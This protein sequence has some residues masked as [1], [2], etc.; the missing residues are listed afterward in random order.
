MSS[1][2]GGT[3]LAI[4]GSAAI[5][6]V[7]SYESGKRVS[8]A[9]DKAS[10]RTAQTTDNAV[11]LQA[12]ATKAAAETQAAATRYASDNQLKATRESNALLK[13]QY[14][15]TR[16]D[17][18]PWMIA[19]KNALKAIQNTPDFKFTPE[20][21]D[22]LKDPSYDFR[23]QEGI[24]ALDRSAASRGR[25]LSGAQDRAVTRYGSDLA[26]QE[27]GNA[28]ARHM[29]KEAQ[30]FN[31]EKSVYDT[32]LNTKKSL[33][34]VGQQAVNAVSSSGDS[35]SRSMAGNTMSGAN[36]VGNYA[37]S[38][39]R[40]QNALSMSGVE[41]QNALMMRGAN[42]QNSLAMQ[43]ARAQAGMYG[44]IATSINNGIGN[45]LLANKLG[46]L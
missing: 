40:A 11:K 38:G 22:F 43:G 4:L 35:L 18:M 27:Y 29:S 44:G 26:S 23:K 21:F 9:T 42:S 32:N 14:D 24:N 2:I 33:A 20:T 41:A 16:L 39:A 34:G 15:Q 12:D 28:F 37:M 46:L 3:G 25:L 10:Q 1:F 13:E 30:R 31:E 45:Y 6:A 17:H 7:A 19:G 5:G 36:A 8:K